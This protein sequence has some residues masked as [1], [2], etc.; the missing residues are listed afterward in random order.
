MVTAARKIAPNTFAI[1]SFN[2]AGSYT[3]DLAGAKATCSCPHYTK[4]LAGTDKCCK[5]IEAVE[6]QLPMIEAMEKAA[7]CTD[8]Q[9]ERLLPKY[10]NDPIIGGALRVAR[11]ERKAE[12]NLRDIFA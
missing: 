1:D 9:I 8:E 4:R 11:A 6:A 5:H 7:G 2:G 3:V 10:G 12:Q